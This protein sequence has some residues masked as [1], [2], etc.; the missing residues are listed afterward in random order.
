MMHIHQQRTTPFDDQKPGTA[1]LR[2]KARVT[3]KVEKLSALDTRR[4]I[5]FAHV[6]VLLLDANDMLEKQD[7]DPHI[8]DQ[9]C[10]IV[11]TSFDTHRLSRRW[12]QKRIRQWL[13]SLPNN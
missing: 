2:K 3:D 5:D 13:E 9:D 4:S 8:K 1:G 12:H 7:L 6:V 11:P 10:L